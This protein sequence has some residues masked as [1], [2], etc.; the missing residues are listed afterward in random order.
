MG[1]LIFESTVLPSKQS[2]NTVLVM[3]TQVYYLSLY[4]TV[5][6]GTKL[7]VIH[8]AA[9]AENSC[10]PATSIVAHKTLTGSPDPTYMQL[11]N[12]PCIIGGESSL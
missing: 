6:G 9:A 5:Q 1:A 4:G 10:T 8:Q 11:T 7:V 12:R 3:S 2:Q